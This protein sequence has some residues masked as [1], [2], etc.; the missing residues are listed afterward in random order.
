MLKPDTS[1]YPAST[2]HIT[3]YYRT[4]CIMHIPKHI[5]SSNMDVN[6]INQR[7]FLSPISGPENHIPE[8]KQNIFHFSF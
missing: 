8:F 3:T 1:G 6:N 7:T 5:S 4:V 2:R